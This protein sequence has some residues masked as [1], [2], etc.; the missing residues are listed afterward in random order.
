MSDR[1]DRR[2]VLITG[3]TGFKGAWLAWWLARRG[4]HVTGYALAPEPDRPSLFA[5]LRLAEVV[6]SAIGDVRDAESVRRTMTRVRPEVVLHLAAQA[7]VRVSYA[8]PLETWETNVVGTAIV[9]DA[10]RAQSAL[11]AVVVVTSDKCYENRGL[12]RGYREDDPLGGRDPYSASKA[13][14]E[15]V[16]ASYRASYFGDGPLLATVRAGNV[17]GGGDWA[18]DRLIPDVVQALRDDAAVVLRYPDAVRPWQHVLEPLHAYLSVAERLIDGDGSVASAYNVGPHDDDHRTVAEVV[19][20]MY[21]AWGREPA[22]TRD[23]SA[24]AEEAAVLRLDA[25]KAARELG[26]VPR[27]GLDEACRR[28]ASWYRAW[29]DGAGA[30]A[31]CD[32]DLDAYEEPACRV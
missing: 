8:A 27:F 30:R 10:A 16:A 22:W 29:A 13:A 12:T 1:W 25:A 18:R 32:A 6:D 5:E 21:A 11:R 24:Q 7:I 20:R 26:V 9:L 28:T 2:R 3:H 23:P 17:I 4:A 15:I 14:Q 19:D 31:C